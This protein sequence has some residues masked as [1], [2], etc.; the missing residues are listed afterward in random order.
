[1]T[2]PSRS[3]PA[4]RSKTRREYLQRF[5]VLLRLEVQ[6]GPSLGRSFAGLCLFTGQTVPAHPGRLDGGLSAADGLGT[7]C[8][9]TYERLKG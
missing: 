3:R 9:P 7:P 5:A 8:R 6:G 4:W 1:V 2:Q